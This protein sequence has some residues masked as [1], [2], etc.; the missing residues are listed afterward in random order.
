[1]RSVCSRS[2][3]QVHEP[4][5]RSSEACWSASASPA[6]ARKTCSGKLTLVPGNHSAPGISRAPSTCSYGVAAWTSKYSQIE[7]QNAWTS[8]TD[9]RRSAS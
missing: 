7:A 8:S 1:M 3:P 5:A 2:S 9:Q 4:S 6:L